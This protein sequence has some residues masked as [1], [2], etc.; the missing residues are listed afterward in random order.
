MHLR[1]PKN[2]PS[3]DRAPECCRPHAPRTQ[4]LAR[5]LHAARLLRLV[6][7]LAASSFSFAPII[8]YRLCMQ[9]QEQCLDRLFRGLR[10]DQMAPVCTCLKQPLLAFSGDRP[11]RQHC[12]FSEARLRELR[13]WPEPSITFTFKLPPHIAQLPEQE[14]VCAVTMVAIVNMASRVGKFHSMFHM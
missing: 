12:A 7:P 4:H 9:A 14:Q 6:S 10:E 3:Q 11:S 1:L 5:L 13:I 2:I 8:T